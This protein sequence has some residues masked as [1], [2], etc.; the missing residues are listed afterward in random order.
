[1]AYRFVAMVLVVALVA[2]CSGSAKEH[3]LDGSVL[4]LNDANFV[5]SGQACQGTGDF[6]DL[7]ADSPVKIT[8]QGKDPVFTKLS[9]GEITPEGNCR[10]RFTPKIPEAASYVF[11]VGG[12]EPVTRPKAMIDGSNG[13]RDGWWVTLGWDS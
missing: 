13:S 12:R 6:W 8:P 9:Q 3:E 2:A 5:A 4:I 11:E 1:M 7:K 10:L